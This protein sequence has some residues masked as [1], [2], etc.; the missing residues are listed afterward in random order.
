MQELIRDTDVLISC[1]Q[2]VVRPVISELA[3]DRIV[4]FDDQLGRVARMKEL[5]QAEVAAC[6]LGKSGVA[7]TLINTLMERSEAI[8]REKH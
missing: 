5:C 3:S 7:K 4:D 6:F 1:Y 8:S 2:N